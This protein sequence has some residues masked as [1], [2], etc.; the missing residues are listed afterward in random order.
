MNIDLD[1][2]QITNKL[3]NDLI[4]FS[5]GFKKASFLQLGFDENFVILDL[6]PHFK[7]LYG[8]DE[9]QD[10]YNQGINLINK[11]KT[12]NVM[13]FCGNSSRTPLNRYDVVLINSSQQ[14]VLTDTINVLSKNFNNDPFLIV[15]FGYN[16]IKDV[17]IFCDDNFKNFMVPIGITDPL[18]GPEAVACAFN[19]ETKKKYLD[20]LKEKK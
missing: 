20:L 2:K 15:Y 8:I 6:A 12:K 17:R 3:K 16:F 11:N 10:L 1:S 14:N 7:S 4:K 9:S 5:K 13:I 18:L 19:G